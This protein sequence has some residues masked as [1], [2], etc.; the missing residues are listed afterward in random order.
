MTSE[1]FLSIKNSIYPRQSHR[2]PNPQHL[3]SLNSPWNRFDPVHFALIDKSSR[4]TV[5]LLAGHPSPCGQQDGHVDHDH[6]R[7][8]RRSRLQTWNPTKNHSVTKQ[9]NLEMS[10]KVNLNGKNKTY[11]P[12]NHCILV[13]SLATLLCEYTRSSALSIGENPV[14]YGW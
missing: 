1:M 8:H 10:L 11:F 7:H 12:H 4:M 13:Y 5:I 9:K 3:I 2:C 6:Q 14:R